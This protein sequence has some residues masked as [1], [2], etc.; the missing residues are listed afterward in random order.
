VDNSDN[1]YEPKQL[2]LARSLIANGKKPEA[3]QLIRTTLRS[4]ERSFERHH[5]VVL[6]FQLDVVRFLRECQLQRQANRMLFLCRKRVDELLGT[7]H[8]FDGRLSAELGI[9]LT[10]YGLYYEAQQ[11]FSQAQELLD[12]QT[13]D[14]NQSLM[15]DMAICWCECNLALDEHMPANSYEFITETAGLILQKN[16]DQSSIDP[17]TV[18]RIIHVLSHGGQVSVLLDLLGHLDLSK[19]KSS[20]REWL[21]SL[22]EQ[23]RG[24]DYAGESR[25]RLLLLKLEQLLELDLAIEDLFGVLSELDSYFQEQGSPEKTLALA[26]EI[27]PRIKQKTG[28]NSIQTA[29]YFRFCGDLAYLASNYH[30]SIEYFSRALKVLQ[31]TNQSCPPEL[32]AECQ[33]NIGTCHVAIDNYPTALQFYRNAL[34][35][36]KNLAGFEH[37]ACESVL[38]IVL[39]L[40][41]QA[42]PKDAVRYIRAFRNKLGSSRNLTQSLAW[43]RL[44]GIDEELSVKSTSSPNKENRSETSIIEEER[45]DL[46]TNGGGESKGD[47]NVTAELYS[48]G[49]EYIENK[50]YR[51]AILAFERVIEIMKQNA[52]TSNREIRPVVEMLVVGYQGLGDSSKA[53]E[54]RSLRDSLALQ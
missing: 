29:Q 40:R 6:S 3:M 11:C 39:L 31:T 2:R 54:M 8:P 4:L 22:A 14:F 20:E 16:S 7:G 38:A 52:A 26:E 50:E 51:K 36:R 25:E 15:L 48:R 47:L 28:E 5:S 35:C 32:Y 27:L 42:R 1:Y 21:I 12:L 30:L 24:Q 19:F 10:G 45:L 18:K 23:L 9:T 41:I 37:M 53:N 17:N 49:L 13:I 34:R 46:T 43:R 44:Q 33:H